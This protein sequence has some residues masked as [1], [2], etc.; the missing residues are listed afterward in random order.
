MVS[1]FL[2]IVA[3]ITLSGAFAPLDWWFLLPISISIFL[4]AV[5]K[6]RYPFGVSITFALVF[7]FLTL[8][9][10]GTYV[11]FL[12]LFLLTV[13]QALFYLPLGFISYRRDRSSRIW[14]ILPILLCADELRSLLPFGGFG[15]NRLAF[16]QANSPYL[17][18]AKYLGDSSL[19]F[20]AISLGIA[21]YLLFAR[22]QKLSIAVVLLLT[23][24]LIIAP[25]VNPGQGSVEILGVQGNVPRLGLDFNSQA[26]EV[27]NYHIKETEKALSIGEKKPDVII[28]PE[29]S[30]DVDPFMNVSI[31]EKIS[32]LAQK[33]EVPI[34]VGAVLT[35]KNGP[36]NASILWNAKGKAI[37]IYK[38]RV[39]TPFGEY[40]PL[41]SLA[42][43]VSPLAKNVTD[44]QAGNSLLA[45][46]IGQI[47]AG[48]IICYEIINDRAVESMSRIS[49]ILIVQTNNA[50]FASRAQ[51]YQQLNISRIRAVE[52]DRWAMSVSTTGLSAV[53]DNQ[54]DIKEITH[55]N[56]P[57][58]L[59]SEMKLVSSQS[60][61]NRL[62][63]SA[64]L[65]LMLISVL[66]YIRKVGRNEK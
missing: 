21:L 13:L 30:V 14:L 51:S 31:N 37:S 43:I 16:S 60:L 28:W 57:D 46:K 24:V 15:W 45:H 8:H 55:M 26:Q 20:V 25:T 6:T 35:S 3:G 17:N 66:I 4:Y 5:T 56:Q 29:N 50:T 38:K 23:T 65:I 58:Y 32:N 48:P 18:V 41:R 39:L 49:N 61:A 2:S 10:A 19:T 54:G 34:I 27:F 44:F 1:F 33:Y 63:N 53:I 22:A 36:I 9:W 12:P 52:N 47:K 64:S 40:I 42:E 59:Y 62:G 11:G 7:N